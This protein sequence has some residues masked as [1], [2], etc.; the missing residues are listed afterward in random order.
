[1]YMLMSNNDTPEFL[2]AFHLLVCH[3]LPHTCD[4][5]RSMIMILQVTGTQN[6]LTDLLISTTFTHVF[7]D[8]LSR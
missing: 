4:V 2:N 7:Y 3:N 8:K 5:C 6:F 1:M